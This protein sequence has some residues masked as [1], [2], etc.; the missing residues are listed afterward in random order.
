MTLDEFKAKYLGQKVEADG[1]YLYQCVD[2]IK[3]YC[4]D[5]LQT[6]VI[7]GNAV[8]YSKNPLPA[9]FEYFVN[10]LW[11]IPPRGAIAVWNKEVGAGFGHVSIV[12]DA[13][14]MKFTSL[15]QNWP[16]GSPVAQVV[17]NY[18]NVSGFL[19]KRQ[20]DVVSRYNAL[21]DDLRN[22]AVRYPKL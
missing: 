20:T 2:L 4:T 16:T 8:D 7:M 12:L 21:V 5:V 22:I 10:H 14:I 1:Q 15:D 18:T 9:Q 3:Q 6:P 11:Y 17:H 13:T 19:V